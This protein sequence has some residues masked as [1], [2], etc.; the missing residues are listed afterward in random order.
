MN[1]QANVRELLCEEFFNLANP[2][3]NALGA[4]FDRIC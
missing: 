1:H 4:G 3:I 2:A